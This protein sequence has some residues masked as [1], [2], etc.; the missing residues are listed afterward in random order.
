M[1]RLFV[2]LFSL[3]TLQLR[4]VRNLDVPLGFKVDPTLNRLQ[5]NGHHLQ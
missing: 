4:S 1:E 5:S 3:V 2:I